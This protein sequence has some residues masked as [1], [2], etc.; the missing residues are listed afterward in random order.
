MQLM[1]PGIMHGFVSHSLCVYMQYQQH[2]KHRL[3]SDLSFSSMHMHISTSQ[4]KTRMQQHTPTHIRFPEQQ[5][6]NDFHLLI[7]ATKA[8]NGLVNNS[9]TTH[10]IHTELIYCLSGAKSIS[11]ALNN[12]GISDTRYDFP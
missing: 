3:L 7:A 1:T 10:G 12:F 6:A 4:G 5:V 2:N 9:L 8:M 11:D